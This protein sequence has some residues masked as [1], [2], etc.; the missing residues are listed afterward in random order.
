[1]INLDIDIIII[2]HNFSDGSN[3]FS[4]GNDPATNSGSKSS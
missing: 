3:Q 4:C 1:M 2:F